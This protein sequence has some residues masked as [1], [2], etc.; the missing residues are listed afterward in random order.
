MSTP[1][2]TPIHRLIGDRPIAERHRALI[3]D[4]ARRLEAIDVDIDGGLPG[5]MLRALGALSPDSATLAAA[6]VIC[7]ARATDGEGEPP[8]ETP[9]D[10]DDVRA[11]VEQFGQVVRFDQRDVPDSE[12]RAEGLRRLILALIEDVRVA[13]LVIAWQLA[14]MQVAR[15]PDTRRALARE[16]RAIHA[17]LANRLGVW[18]L[19]WQLEDLAFRYLE[20]EA[21]ARI[22]RLVAE[23]RADRERAIAARMEVDRCARG[24]RQPH[25]L[26]GRAPLLR[27]ARPQS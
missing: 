6:L 13:L 11:L 19:K 26:R 23:Q 2:P 16:T 3:D 22:E 5:R 12:Q 9:L 14:R 1:A 17:P 24:A 27:G 21:H 18:Q 8:D 10:C 20:P 7:A 15:E 25:E 4:C